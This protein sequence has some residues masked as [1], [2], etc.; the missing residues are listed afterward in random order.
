MLRENLD[1]ELKKCDEVLRDS[2]LK[3]IEKI[4]VLTY[5]KSLLEEK[6]RLQ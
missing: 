2:N 5:K 3:N 6:R 1:K 4:S